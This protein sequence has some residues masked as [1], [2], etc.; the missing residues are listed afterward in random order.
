MRQNRRLAVGTEDLEA[1][2]GVLEDVAHGNATSR[3]RK[4][5]VRAFLHGAGRNQTTVKFENGIACVSTRRVRDRWNT[6][7]LKRIA[8]RY[9]RSL[10][11]KAVFLARGSKSQWI[12]DNA[13]RAIRRCVRLQ[14]L[15]T[16]RLAGQWLEDPLLSGET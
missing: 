1:F 13:A 6:H 7:V 4:A 16:L 14:S 8:K 9:G 5:L 15:T 10:R 2:H 12:R 11:V 3:V